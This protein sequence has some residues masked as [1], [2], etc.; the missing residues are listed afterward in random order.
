MAFAQN[1]QIHDKDLHTFRMQVDDYATAF[2][3]LRL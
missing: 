2:P 1:W 3:V